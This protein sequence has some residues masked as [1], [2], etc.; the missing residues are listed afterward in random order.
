MKLY[1][2]NGEPEGNFTIKHCIILIVIFIFVW[3]FLTI[4]IK[5]YQCNQKG[6]VYLRQTIFNHC[7]K[8]ET[9]K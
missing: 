6:G 2:Y 3:A 1:V 4:A 9:I 5:E 7:V 8:I